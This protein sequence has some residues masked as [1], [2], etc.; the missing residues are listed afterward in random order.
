MSWK[1][2]AGIKALQQ[3]AK[4]LQTIRHFF[5][6]RDVLEVETPVLSQAAV[7]DIHLF[8]F[9]THFNGAQI[10]SAKP[11]R[12]GLPLYMQTSPEFHMKRLLSAGSGCIFQMSKV[13][14]NEESGRFHNPEFTLLEWYRIG[15]DH[16]RLMDEMDQL[17]QLILNSQPARR[18]TYQDAFLEILDVDPLAATLEQLK[19]SGERLN[20]GDVLN[21]E[22]DRDT[23]LQLLFC[24]AIEP[25]IAQ[26]KPCFV[27]NF[28]ASQA[29]LAKI[30]PDDPRVAERFEV[31]FK[32]IEL[33]N[34]F[35]ELSDL[36]EQL[37]RFEKDNQLR[38]QKGLA[39]MP[40]DLQFIESLPFLPDC[41]GVALGIDR[42]VMLATDKKHI[43]DV[44][45]FTIKGA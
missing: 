35:H 29:A 30:S 8:C 22:Q 7:T 2:S 25:V 13:F 21:N 11:D 23:V 27:Y 40:I 14:R 38:A 36:Q 26:D 31:Y 32:G 20:L 19:K 24:F 39:Q 44:I 3:R 33:A 34:G 5:I 18:C 4:I 45:S 28:P 16:F 10:S 41:A 6:T 15:F 17:L 43:D 9:K 1:P 37:R 42:L 12:Q